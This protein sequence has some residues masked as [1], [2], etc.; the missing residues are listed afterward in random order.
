MS[1]HVD[2]AWLERGR[3]FAA[4]YVAPRAADWERADGQPRDAF[5]EAARLG[6][7]GLEVPQP[8]GGADVN[9]MTKLAIC[10]VLAGADMAF[11][12]AMINTQNVAAKLAR[13]A[14]AARRRDLIE[15]LM[16]GEL[17]GATALSEPAAGSDFG[18]IRT[19]AVRV[20]DGWQLNGTK[21]WITNAGFADLF[22]LYAQTDP[23]AGGRGVAAFLVDAR[24]PGFRRGEIYEMGGARAIGAGEFHLDDYHVPDADLLSGPGEGFKHALG[25]VNGARVYVAAMCA[26]MIRDALE[27]ALAYGER[28]ESF[29]AP[30][31]DHQ[32]LSWSL[33]DVTAQLAALRALTRD[34]GA[35]IEAGGDAVLAAAVAKKL[36]GDV[37]TPAIAACMQAMGANGLKRDVNLSRHLLAARVATLADGSNEMMNERVIASLRKTGLPPA[38]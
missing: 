22:V 21:G 5:R 36:A 16:R 26:G 17:L 4:N 11:T 30:L 2:E 9:F 18:A 8:F 10:E 34:A 33:A 3:A 31:L 13:A 15:A 28:R 12:F 1:N 23:A 19:R 35:L 25:S 14:D 7:L 38:F 6:F 37:T 32:G 27:T 29:G 24:R 20:T